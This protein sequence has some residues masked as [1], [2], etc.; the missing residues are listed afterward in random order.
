MSYQAEQ[1]F[2]GCILLNNKAFELAAEIE[3]HHFADR[4]HVIIYAAMLPDLKKGKSIDPITLMPALGEN[5]KDIGGIQYLNELASGSHSP[6]N[7]ERY[8]EIL[9]EA[10]RRVRLLDISAALSES[11]YDK[12]PTLEIVSATQ[13]SLEGLHQSTDDVSEMHCLLSNH[14][15]DM[16]ERIS[17]TKVFCG[18]GLTDLDE[19]L[20]G[21]FSGGDLVIVAGR[22]SMGKTAFSLSV[23]LEVSKRATVLFFSM[24]MSKSQL[25]D[26]A[27]AN[28]GGIDLGWVRRPDNDESG[29]SSEWRLYSAAQID[30]MNRKL[31]VTDKPARKLLDIQATSKAVHRKS[32]LGMIVVDY[33]GLMSGGDGSNRNL[34]LGE[35]TKGLKALAKDLNIPV[36]CLA[37]LNRSVES[38]VDKRP[39]MS[40]LRDSGEIENDADTIMM[41]YRD[42]YYNRDTHAKN[43]LEVIIAKQRQGETGSVRLGFDGA[44]QRVSDY[45][46]LAKHNTQASP[47]NKKQ[48]ENDS[49]G[50]Y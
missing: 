38:R 36:V 29:E 6:V 23:A 42:E 44:K 31:C 15:I 45:Y 30:L 28:V 13:K 26:R 5:L 18:T 9:L 21:G 25:M 20:V 41:L 47:T 11:I 2:L 3:P 16:D 17:G 48:K 32:P 10:Y 49:S 34:Q 46:Q 8:A 1:A 33:L 35:Y 50:W 22:P 39:L 43:E 12:A 37:Q 24:E 27:V 40:D 14:I 19:M 7:M 4:N